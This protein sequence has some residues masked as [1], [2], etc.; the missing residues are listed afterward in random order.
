[1]NGSAQKARR[2]FMRVYTYFILPK[3]CA[4]TK[5][6]KKILMFLLASFYVCII[7]FQDVSAATIEAKSCSYFDVSN[8]VLSA[9]RGDTVTVPAGSCTWSN[10]LT[11]TK[12]IRLKG[13]GID[14]TII[15]SKLPLASGFTGY[16]L[17]N[18]K[19]SNPV[20]DKDVLFE[21]TGFTLDA[22]SRAGAISLRNESST[23]VRKV[24]VHHNKIINA[25]GGDTTSQNYVNTIL[26][27]GTVWGVID[28]NTITG[29]PH[30]DNYGYSSRDCGKSS[31]DYTTY[32]P[33]SADNMYYEDNTITRTTISPGATFHLFVSG[34]IGG[35]YC[36][37]YSDIT[38][39]NDTYQNTFDMHGTQ[40]GGTPESPTYRNRSTMGAEIYGNR[41]T[42]TY[43]MSQ[44]WGHRGGRL[45]AFFNYII[46]GSQNVRL[47]AY[48]EAAESWAPTNHKCPGLGYSA[49]SSDGES[50]KQTKSYY[51]NN[52][53]SSDNSILI[54]NI[55]KSSNWDK[56]GGNQLIEN[57]SFWNHKSN[58]DGTAGM[59]CGTL[60]D[61]PKNCRE[62]VGYWVTDQ[63]CSKIPSG[64]YGREPT[65]PISGILYRCTS[66]NTWTAYYTPYTYPHPLREGGVEGIS[67]PKGFKLLK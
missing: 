24:R 62:G 11:I 53:K 29:I 40:I 3:I 64:S 55:T 67:A 51:W 58:F 41:I 35:R 27:E 20:T 49:C 46:N 31:W 43:S 23:P 52:R 16:W 36:F 4:R 60:E 45:L 59:G 50:Q 42:N 26:V 28:N 14:K 57:L 25:I 48:D 44:P 56:W 1:M 65:T 15:T 7:F 5:T 37:R 32:T 39:L 47:N 33:G 2:F 8:A 17:I 34:G 18:Y 66:T 61:R 21:I 38:T 13:E 9:Q 63:L 54:T 12:A 6:L 10:E 19:P 30:F 22:A